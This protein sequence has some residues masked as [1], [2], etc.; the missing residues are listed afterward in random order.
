MQLISKIANAFS[1]LLYPHYCEGCGTDVLPNHHLLCNS[2][3]NTLPATNFLPI[4]NNPIEK[5]FYG[6]IPISMAGSAFYF[7]KSSLLQHVIFQMKYKGNTD[8]GIFLG[9]LLGEALLASERF[10]DIDMIVP[11]PLNKKRQEKRGY[12]QAALIAEGISQILYKPINTTAVIRTVNTKTQTHENRINRWKNMQE[13]FA[14]A[15]EAA[16]QGKHILLVDDV[17]TTG[18]TLESCGEVI[19][20]IPNTKLSIATVAYT[21]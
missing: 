16:I 5:I 10:T 8:A 18:A 2:C 3:T 14:I 12:N 19:V 20:Q 21:Q 1:H 13:V 15:H 6:R 17:I 9:K 11:L 4:A 7:T